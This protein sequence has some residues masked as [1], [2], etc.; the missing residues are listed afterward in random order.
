LVVQN[1]T[2]IVSTESSPDGVVG[3]NGDTF[4]FTSGW[5][6]TSAS[7]TQK[8]GLFEARVKLPSPKATGIWPA[9]W[10]LP[11]LESGLCWPVGGE[12]DVFEYTALGPMIPQG[13][14]NIFGSYRW[15]KECGTDRQP[16][17]GAA[18]PGPARA[19]VDWEQ[20]FHVMAAAWGPDNIT[21]YVDGELYEVVGSTDADLPPAPM[22]VILN[23]AVAW[24][25]PPG[26]DAVYPAVTVWDW[27]RV[28]EW[29]S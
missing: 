15:G 8:F 10:T 18:Y 23:T 6:D 19:K 1:S 21:F 25:W 20:E 7:F 17:P 29:N 3:S 14:S 22:Y 5:I 9:F 13:G 24:Y 4:Y 2:L 16:L 12:I 27:V 11:A 28:F 26:P